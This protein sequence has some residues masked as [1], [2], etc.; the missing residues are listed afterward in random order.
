MKRTCETDCKTTE[1]SALFE[2]R[3]SREQSHLILTTEWKRSLKDRSKTFPGWT[4]AYRFV[5]E[6]VIWALVLSAGAVVEPVAEASI[7]DTPEPSPPVGAGACKPLH[8]V[9]RAGTLCKAEEER[10]CYQPGE[11][12]GTEI[13][14]PSIF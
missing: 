9:R 6:T 3:A 1:E 10:F 11:I 13:C 7:V 14:R 5:E 4:F 8:V 12:K 2:P